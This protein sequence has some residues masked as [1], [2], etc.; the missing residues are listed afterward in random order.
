[1]GDNY[2][3]SLEGPLDSMP[4]DRQMRTANLGGFTDLVRGLGAE[5]RAILE[6][7]GIDPRTIRDPDAYI[8][9]KSLVDVLQ[10]NTATGDW[11]HVHVERATGVGLREW[12]GVEYFGADLDV[13]V[14]AGRQ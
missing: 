4:V 12:N 9:S 3:Y 14:R 10:S 5:P 8:D 6:R 11:H 2:F 1:M 13:I 7:H